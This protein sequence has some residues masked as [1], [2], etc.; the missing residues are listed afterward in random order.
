[1]LSILPGMINF[2]CNAGGD[3]HICTK[4]IYVMYGVYVTFPCL[5][6]MPCL[7]NIHKNTVN[8]CKMKNTHNADVYQVTYR[9]PL[10]GSTVHV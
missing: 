1:M 6:C 10:P 2:S 7:T 3:I 8:V 9:R 4:C 5:L